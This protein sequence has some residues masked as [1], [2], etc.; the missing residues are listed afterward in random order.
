MTILGQWGESTVKYS[1]IKLDRTKYCLNRWL[2]KPSELS[3]HR[4][5]LCMEVRSISVLLLCTKVDGVKK[6]NV[7]MVDL[8]L[9][10]PSECMETSENGVPSYLRRSYRYL[11]ISWIL[12]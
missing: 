3:Y 11:I 1:R 4:T 5:V 8:I 12:G 2:D 10:S 6:C 7:T 9:T